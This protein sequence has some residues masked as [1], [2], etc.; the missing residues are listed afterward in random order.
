MVLPKGASRNLHSDAGQ[1]GVNG[2]SRLA[3][4]RTVDETRGCW[5]SRPVWS[6]QQVKG[7]PFDNTITMVDR[8]ELPGRR[9]AKRGPTQDILGVVNMI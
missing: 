9:T 7:M 1:Q 2:I 3:L 4:K 6:H 8:Q 5:I